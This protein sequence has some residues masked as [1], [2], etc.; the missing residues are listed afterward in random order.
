MALAIELLKESVDMKK[1][2]KYY[3]IAK[4][5]TNLMMFLVNDILDFSQFEAEKL[6]V[7]LQEDVSVENILKDCIEL[8]SFKAESKGIELSY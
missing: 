2:Y 5:C 7:N 6:V 4:N 8:L 3:R 1:G